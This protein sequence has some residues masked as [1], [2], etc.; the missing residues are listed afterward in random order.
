M[1]QRFVSAPE[2]GE[3]SPAKRTRAAT[4]GEASAA[5]VAAVVRKA[6]KAS[7][8]SIGSA[9]DDEASPTQ[10]GSDHGSPAQ[11][12]NSPARKRFRDAVRSASKSSV[13]SK[14]SSRR[15]SKSSVAD[16]VAE[17]PRT[18]PSKASEFAQRRCAMLSGSSPEESFAAVFKRL[19][20]DGEVHRDCVAQALELVGARYVQQWADSVYANVTRYVT[21]DQ[22]E[23]ISFVGAYFERQREEY[24][25]AFLRADSDNS[26]SIDQTEL[27]A[28]L[29]E[30]GI[31]P[32]DIVIAEILDEVDEDNSGTLQLEEFVQVLEI[33]EER[34]GFSKVEFA[35][36]MDAFKIH[37]HD[38]SG[39]LNAG[40]A[41][42]IL[43]Y[44]NYSLKRDRAMEIFR[45]IDIDESGELNQREFLVFMRKV[46]ECELGYIRSCLERFRDQ[47][48]ERLTSEAK[49]ERGD[50]QRVD[51]NTS[52]LKAA[53]LNGLLNA[54]GNFP[55]REAVL[56]AAEDAGISLPSSP[57]GASARSPLSG[58]PSLS[59]LSACEEDLPVTISEAWRFLEVYRGREGL[60]RAEAS[61]NE[62]AMRRHVASG[63]HKVWLDRLEAGRALSW[64]GWRVS[65]QVQQNFVGEVDVEGSER[66]RL[67]EFHKLVRK[68]KEREEREVSAIVDSLTLVAELPDDSESLSAQDFTTALR[69]LGCSSGA[70]AESGT[71]RADIIR[72]MLRRRAQ[73]RSTFRHNS[74]FSPHEVKEQK[75]VFNY[76]DADLSG[77]IGRSELQRLCSEIFPE[78][79]LP[80]KQLRKLLGNVDE[81]GGGTL[82]FNEFLDL[83]R[84]C[85][86]IYDEAKLRKERNIVESTGFRAHEVKDFRA[87]FVGEDRLISDRLTFEAVKGL[88]HGITPLGDKLVTHLSR[89]WENHLA[90]DT[91]H[92]SIDFPDFLRLMKHLLEVNF[93]DITS[94]SAKLVR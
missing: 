8:G 48:A 33:L 6:S 23:F 90:L 19:Q 60:T 80:S 47:K 11:R 59:A 20:G 85:Y 69:I 93:A 62:S 34:E 92:W 13:G 84:Q 44:L 31:I 14:V 71:K 83:M 42:S 45:Q 58:R 51:H 68:F 86:D 49:Q 63:R 43:E 46:R 53:A 72:A 29:E 82:D 7:K 36:L 54:F 38:G 57:S 32:M 25:A 39:E 37:D 79:V 15:G 28:L 21:L 40:E 74:S 9:I 91:T 16:S 30:L 87:I 24:A 52:D 4:E 67:I 18:S 81:D 70:E 1:R 3:A 61:D 78:D 22:K 65:F 76:Y 66:L 12:R 56:E 17:E 26:G 75:K 64:L 10:R 73:I 27:C 41:L 77:D 89:I 2:N 94:K 50:G 55:E 88:L 5:K 35:R